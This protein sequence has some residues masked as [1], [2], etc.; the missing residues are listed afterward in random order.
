VFLSGTALRDLWRY[1]RRAGYVFPDYLPSGLA[2]H[3]DY[4]VAILGALPYCNP[5]YLARTGE[6]AHLG[7][8]YIPAINKNRQ[9]QIV[10][11]DGLTS[12]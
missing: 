10:T 3:S 5:I 12:D 4:L 9:A 2:E 11:A 7:L 8:H 1:V 6:E